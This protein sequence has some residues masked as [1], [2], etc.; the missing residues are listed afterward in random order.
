LSALTI[1]HMDAQELGI[2]RYMD[3]W[4]SRVILTLIDDNGRSR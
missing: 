4:W 1:I 3:S 2:R